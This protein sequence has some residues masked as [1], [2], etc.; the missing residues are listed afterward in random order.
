M[1]VRVE[2]RLTPIGEDLLPV[3]RT[4]KG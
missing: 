4:I 2:Y 3:I 1:P